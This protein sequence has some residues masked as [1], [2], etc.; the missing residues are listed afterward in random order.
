M[1]FLAGII[2]STPLCKNLWAKA[3]SRCKGLIAVA[4][5]VGIALLLIAVTACLLNGSLNPFMYFRF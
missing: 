1:V 3:S 5:P 2:G 4:E